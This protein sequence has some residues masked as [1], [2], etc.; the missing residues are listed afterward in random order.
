MPIMKQED[1]EF[2][3]AKLEND[4]DLPPSM[5]IGDLGFFVDMQKL[6]Y[7]KPEEFYGLFLLA[8]D[9]YYD[10]VEA[11]TYLDAGKWLTLYVRGDHK[12]AQSNYELLLDYAQK[13]NL[14]LGDF[15]IERTVVDHYISS[16][17]NLYITEIQIPIID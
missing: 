2:S 16:D 13:D 4:H 11:L 7:R 3:L 14:K 12:T 10:K 15:A 5:I 1:W 8:D 9:S 6:D 17:P